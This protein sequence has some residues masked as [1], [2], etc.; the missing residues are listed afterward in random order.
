VPVYNALDPETHHPVPPN[1]EYACDLSFLGNRL[2]DREARVEEFF[3]KAASR[4]P[5]RKFLLG[6]SGWQSK[7][8]PENVRHIGHVGTSSHNAFFCSALATLNVNRDSMARYGFSPPTRVFEAAGS[9]ACIIT[10]KWVGIE[11]FL[12]PDTEVLVAANGGEVADIL[13]GL[14]EKRS[15]KIAAAAR[16]RI[17]AEHTYA[18]R[19]R[20]VNRLL[21]DFTATREAAE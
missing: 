1:D 21:D 2:P 19:A 16:A 12:E 9:G 6:G 4:S 15:R 14:T 5:Q 7:A 3:L 13:A 18:H 11:E 20:Q 8:I 10:D 17:L